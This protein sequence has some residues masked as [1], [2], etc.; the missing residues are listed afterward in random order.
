MKEFRKT[1]NGLFICEECCKIYKNKKNG[2]C[3]HIYKEHNPNIYYDKWLKEEN[4]NKCKICNN[5][6]EFWSLSVGYANCC[7]KKCQKIYRAKNI[8][9]KTFK[10]YGVK[11]VY[12]LE[13]VKNK[14]NKTMKIKYGAEQT[15]NSKI[16]KEKRKQTFIK[17]YD[18]TC[19][20]LT[21]EFKEKRKQTCLKH[22]GTEN[23]SQNCEN[24][25]KGQ[26]TRLVRKQYKNTNLWYQGSY[27]FDFIDKYL[28]I[29]PDIQRAPSIKYEFNKKEHYY[30]PDFYIPS[31]NLIIE[32]KNHWLLKRDNEQIEAKTKATISNGFKYIIIIDKDYSVFNILSSS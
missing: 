8:R 29:F 7:S 23:N 28:L 19:Y 18:T 24:F 15:S 26:K 11:N 27:E 25:E 30:H 1:E 20:V 9:E 32:C 13:F 2:L 21:D 17:K 22:F 31:L 10:I 16:L 12:M 3:H 5:E 6:T 4:D 14:R